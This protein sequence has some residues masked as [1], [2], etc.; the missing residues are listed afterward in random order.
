MTDNAMP[1][2]AGSHRERTVTWEDPAPALVQGRQLSGMDWLRSIFEGKLPTPP[3]NALLGAD[4]A[5][6]EPGRVWMSLPAGE[7][8]YNP[9]CVVHGGVLSTVLDTVMACAIHSTLE[10]GEGYT[11]IDLHVTF[12]RAVT[13]ASGRLRFEG[14]VVH[15]GRR[16]AT[17]QGKA[18]DEQGRLCAHAVTTCMIF[19]PG[20]EGGRS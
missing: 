14:E 13:A 10:A 16:V 18:F 17:A 7:H 6:A 8:L 11:T 4:Q 19:R 12:V 9:M 20:A 2:A 15:P 5:G 1:S 3:I